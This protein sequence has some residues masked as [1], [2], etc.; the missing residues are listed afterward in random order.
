[1]L[2]GFLHAAAGI[3]NESDHICLGSLRCS[4][5]H[6]VD[7]PKR[8][9]PILQGYA[10]PLFLGFA[11]AGQRSRRIFRAR[12]TLP[13][14]GLDALRRATEATEARLRKTG[15]FLLRGR[16]SRASLARSAIAK[17]EAVN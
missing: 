16:L 13:R 1:L 11:I 4:S 9:V 2:V 3:A 12:S 14:A 7:R 8:L 10:V 15:L 17:L 5:R 6:L